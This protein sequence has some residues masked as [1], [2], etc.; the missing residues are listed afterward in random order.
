MAAVLLLIV[1]DPLAS[2]HTQAL[3][4]FP[5]I[6]PV[7][8]EPMPE[9]IGDVVDPPWLCAGKPD[10]AAVSV[11][12]PV[13]PALAVDPADPPVPTLFKKYPLPTSVQVVPPYTATTAALLAYATV[14]IIIAPTG[15]IVALLTLSLLGINNCI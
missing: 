9:T 10:C 13:L 8:D 14:V 1:I 7:Y 15:Y 11:V 4:V 2:F 6:A 3:E 12:L 5:L